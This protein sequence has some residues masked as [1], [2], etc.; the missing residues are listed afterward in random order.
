MKRA[1]ALLFF[2]LLSADAC[3]VI[4][5]DSIKV[6]AVTDSGG[7]LSADLGLRIKEGSGEVWTSTEPLVGTSTQTTEKLAVQIAKRYS[8]VVDK[9]DYFF[10]INSNASLVEGPS[11]GAAMTLLV[12]AMLQ[13]KRVPDNVALTGTIAADGSVGP[14]GGVFEKSKE[15]AKTGISVFMIPPGEARQTVKLPSGVQSIN[16][17]S[18]ALSNW[19]LKVVEV[20]NI[21]DILLYAFA[22]PET[23]D[24]NAPEIVLP[25]FVPHP[26]S[27]AQNLQPMH[28]LIEGYI[29]EAGE[30]ISKARS[31]LS[32]TLLND[33][34][35]IDALLRY[36]TNSE[37]TLE[38]ARILLD[39][40]YLY[41]AGNYAFLAIVDSS[42]V[43]D[44]AESPQ[45][46]SPSNTMLDSRVNELS[47]QIDSL[48]VDLNRFVSVDAFE[49]H[50]AAKQR[51]S[52][53]KLNVDE[54]LME[55][56]LVITIGGDSVDEQRLAELLDYEFALAWHNIALD[57][58]ELTKKSSRRVL[59]DQ[60]F[61]NAVDSYIANA[62]KGIAM[63]GEEEAEDISRRLNAAKLE[64]ARGWH[65]AALFD[66]SSALALINAEIFVK[67]KD[68]NQLRDSLQQKIAAL[69]ARLEQSEYSFVWARL[70][71][72]HARYYLMGC[73]FYSQ[74]QQSKALESAKSGLSLV[75]MAEAMANSASSSF[76]YLETLPES[77]F[78]AVMPSQTL[79]IPP[80]LVLVFLASF[81]SAVAA[82]LL[83][84]T[85]TRRM[86]K[87]RHVSL[88]SEIRAVLKKQKRLKQDLDEEKLIASDY[89][90]LSAMYKKRL[91]ELLEERRQLSK[92]YV[93]LDLSKSKL[94]AFE[95]AIRRLRKEFKKGNIT[96]TDFQE[97][98]Q[99]CSNRIDALKETIKSE[100]GK[101][102]AEKT[103]IEESIAKT[104]GKT[105][106]KPKRGK[107]RIIKQGG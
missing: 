29:E 15:A 28:S 78:L 74:Q 45:L 23:I 55:K 70:Y 84:F 82:V 1:I 36:L 19:G 13:D 94:F 100:V 104:E 66:S 22:D 27:F 11:A 91:D 90:K 12:I 107:G 97:A 6:F 21:N 32:G 5:S 53:A 103:A 54:L 26:I 33:P 102:K 64:R 40:N 101:V 73:D 71:L 3:A 20:S 17:V 37:K 59:P 49:W 87:I 63:V 99:F 75:F 9:H 85:L 80:L 48:S 93:E 14:V 56:E 69:E 79:S 61:L 89:S 57:F 24:V 86:P 77:R 35:L 95:R 106:K 105:A 68:L 67:N 92:S 16:L 62:D 72:D 65:Y 42:F 8:N 4:T 81:L 10:D 83:F 76:Q 96:E 2:L 43:K 34:A 38:D 50:V 47:R 44:A 7:A 46:L 39:Q 25:E 98:M 60:H 88:E 30:S 18:Y 52:W 51:L 58:F 31:A 41:S